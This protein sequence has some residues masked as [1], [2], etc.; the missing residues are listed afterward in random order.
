VGDA[1]VIVLDTHAWIWWV[2][3][4]P[5]LRPAVR[6]QIDA[7]TDVRISAITLLEIATAVSLS[8]LVLRP[9]VDRWLDIAQS[10]A[11]L[12]IEPL[13]SSI[14]LESVRLPGEIHRDPADRLIVALARQIAAPL[15]TADRKLLAYQYVNCINAEA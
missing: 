9:S 1:Q 12:R 7:E 11:S 4:H 3:N 10:T 5:R 13:T 15:C 8:R 2:D 6:D 14:C